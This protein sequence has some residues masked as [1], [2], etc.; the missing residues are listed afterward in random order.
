M[1]SGVTYDGNE[2]RKKAKQQRKLA[3]VGQS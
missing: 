3:F 2:H 1:S